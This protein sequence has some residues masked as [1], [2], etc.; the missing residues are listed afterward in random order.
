MLNRCFILHDYCSYER[1]LVSVL[2]AMELNHSVRI[3]LVL[4]VIIPHITTQSSHAFKCTEEMV[5]KGKKY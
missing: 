5:F 2:V 1:L 4:I 3:L